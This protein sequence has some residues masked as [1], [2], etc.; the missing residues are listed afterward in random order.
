MHTSDGL[1]LIIFAQDRDLTNEFFIILK[2]KKKMEVIQLDF[3]RNYWNW[4]AYTETKRSTLR[5]ERLIFLSWL[6]WHNTDFPKKS[7]MHVK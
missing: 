2:M 1:K 4:R 7:W 5:T 6:F 3:E